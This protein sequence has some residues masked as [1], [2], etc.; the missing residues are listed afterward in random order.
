M[1]IGLKADTTEYPICW[2][3]PPPSIFSW[4]ERNENLIFHNGKLALP[5]TI[6]FFM[7]S[8]FKKNKIPK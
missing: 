5:T 3:S 6:I 1:K 8:L 2:V 4:A 7:K